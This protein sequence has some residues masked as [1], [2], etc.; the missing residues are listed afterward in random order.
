[1]A[2][3]AYITM[4]TPE[5]GN[6]RY[7]VEH[8][9][10]KK[11]IRSRYTNSLYHVVGSYNHSATPLV[12]MIG[13]LTFIN[14]PGERDPNKTAWEELIDR[15]NDRVLVGNCIVGRLIEEQTGNYIGGVNVREIYRTSPVISIETE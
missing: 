8:L 5:T 2:A 1:M 14:I 4:G 13:E 10:G 15:I 11:I 6:H 12:E 9:H 7:E 3:R